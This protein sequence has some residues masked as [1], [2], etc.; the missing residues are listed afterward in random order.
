MEFH[1]PT[2]LAAGDLPPSLVASLLE[3]TDDWHEQR[4]KGIG[5]SDAIK[6]MSGDWFLLWEQKTGRAESEDLS[7]VLPVIM[8]TWTEALNRYWF[9]KQT[10][11]IVD[12]SDVGHCT[13]PEYPFLRANLDGRVGLGIWEGKHVNAFAKPEE[14][15]EKYYAQCQH[16]LAVANAPVCYLSVFLGT[17]K[18]EMFEIDEDPEYQAELL[19]REIEFWNFVTTDTA[20]PMVE[21]SGMTALPV[22]D[23]R[24]C[25]MT[26]NNVWASAAA[27]YL[28]NQKAAADFKKA[29]ETLKGLVEGDVKR[30]FGHGVEINRAKNGALRI[31][32]EA[33]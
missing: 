4:L 16:N 24:E 30:A 7:N 29:D 1:L 28:E 21:D 2:N 5:G 10:S 8:G 3:H 32:R 22:D 20:P 17:M 15:R 14:V 11:H 19:A 31:K 33:L 25:D 6:I 26:G 23:M 27:D 9:E 12:L 18:W 13:H